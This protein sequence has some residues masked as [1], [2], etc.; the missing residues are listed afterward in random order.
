[1]FALSAVLA[2]CSAAPPSN[3]I[4]CGPP[5]ALVPDPLRPELTGAPIGPLLVRG[6]YRADAV[7]A[8]AL[9]LVRGRPF[10]MIVLVARDMDAD[11]ALTGERCGDG[12]PL[13]FWL[14]KGGGSPLSLGPFSSPA[15][16]DVMA[17]TG[18]LRAVLPKTQGGATYVG[19]ILFPTSGSYRLEGFAG[20]QSLGQVTLNVSEEPFPA[21]Q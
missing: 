13:R 10:K 9:G 21:G 19:Y 17:S 7:D 15:S 1:M 8:T 16:D 12:Q 11:V 4:S 6:P 5:T 20:D 14:N 3:A 2:A 18:D